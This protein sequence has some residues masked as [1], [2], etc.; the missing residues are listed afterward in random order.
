VAT[1]KQRKR[2]LKEKRH[3]YDL[4]YVDEDGVEHPV[5]RDDEPRKPPGHVS[6]GTTAAKSQKASS[7]GKGGARRG[8]TA[9]PPSWNRVLKRAGIF[10]PIFFITVMLLGGKKMTLPSAAVQT[11]LLVGVFVPFSYFM[12]RLVWQKQ[13][14]RLARDK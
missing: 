7:T 13:Q 4:V 3:D 11:L 12:D 8:R 6:K 9:N 14:K 2:R 10:A 1:Q 5:E